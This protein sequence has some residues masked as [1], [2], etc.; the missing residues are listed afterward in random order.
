[1]LTSIFQEHLLAELRGAWAK[2][3]QVIEEGCGGVWSSVEGW[4]INGEKDVLGEKRLA[5][6]GGWRQMSAEGHLV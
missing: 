5:C 4:R 2:E 1:M 6:L 3:R